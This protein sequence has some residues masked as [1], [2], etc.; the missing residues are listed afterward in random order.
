MIRA[1]AR[2]QIADPL[3][4][5]RFGECQGLVQID[6]ARN[7]LA[8]Q[9]AKPHKK[10]RRKPAFDFPHHLQG[11]ANAILEAHR[12]P[13]G[14]LV[15]EARQEL[16][17]QVAG[18]A[19]QLDRIESGG[20]G[21]GGGI[22]ESVTDRLFFF[23]AHGTR[24]RGRPLHEITGEPEALLQREELHELLQAGEVEGSEQH[25]GPR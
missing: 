8:Q 15:A 19:V 1:H 9:K 14:V 18:G 23:R 5:Q 6:A 10:T 17:Q 13:G 24:P 22:A 16:G 3:G 21:P 25:V 12:R 4:S 7:P 20:A 11:E 2:R